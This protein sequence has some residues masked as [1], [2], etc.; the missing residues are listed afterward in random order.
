MP[1]YPLVL[2]LASTFLFA[3]ICTATKLTAQK[4]KNKQERK[5]TQRPARYTE[6]LSPINLLAI[7][8]NLIPI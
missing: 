6:G 3:R 2:S 1:V 8:I 4:T 5:K 7:S